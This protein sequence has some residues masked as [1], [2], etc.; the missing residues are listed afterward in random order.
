MVSNPAFRY[1]PA[2]APRDFS[3]LVQA[4]FAL[5]FASLRPTFVNALMASVLSQLVWLPWWWSTR[6]RFV[7]S[8]L[9]AWAA[10]DLFLPN[11]SSAT[12]GGLCLLVSLLFFL[13]MLRRQG[14]IARGR[15]DDNTS[16]IRIA[17]QRFPAALLATL[18]YTALLLLALLPVGMA[19]LIGSGSIDP[20]VLLVALLIGLL[21]CAAPLAWISIA[22]SFIY[23]PVLL[24]GHDGWSAQRLSFRL[25]KGRWALS[26]GLVSLTMLAYFGILGMLGLV[27]F[28]MTGALV[29]AL[30]GLTAL[31]RPGWLVFG[32]LLCTP[33]MALLL[34]LCMAGYSVCY[35]ELRLRA[36]TPVSS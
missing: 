6:D 33:L 25:V 20:F 31:L 21:V 27:P 24:D 10:P 14:L 26:A 5:W 34:P 35:E 9:M 4:S 17:L 22:A 18:T 28:L 36:N 13:A 12:L 1:L 32:Q 11:W 15:E 30:D 8:P 2:Q 29:V 19:W 7:E 23:P 3:T 16:D